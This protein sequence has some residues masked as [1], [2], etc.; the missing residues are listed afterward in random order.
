[1]SKP[2]MLNAT[3]TLKVGDRAPDF[4][5]SAANRGEKYSLN[6]LRKQGPVVVEFLRGTW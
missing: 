2:G 6:D 4:E 3:D 5:L 1:M